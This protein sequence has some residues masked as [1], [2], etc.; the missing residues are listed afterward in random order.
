M[1]SILYADFSCPECYVAANRADILA[2]AG[3]SVDFR[4]VEHQ[5]ELPVPGRRPTA[6]DQDTLRSRFTDLRGLL[7]R[8]EEL[9]WT[10]PP[11]IPKTEAAVSAYA[12]VYG[13]PVDDEV[14]RLLFDLYWREGADIGDPNVLRTPL[15]GAVLRSGSAA[16]PLKQVGYAVSV[17]RSPITTLASRRVRTWRQ[18]WQQ[19]GNPALP[20]L[21]V[22]G[23]TLHGAG[24]VR[25]L[26]KEIIYAGAQVNPDLPDPRRYPHVE[27]RPSL[28]WVSQ[29]G[30]RW[31]NVYRPGSDLGRGRELQG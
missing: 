1:S 24:A 11:L 9:A 6:A 20:V 10:M 19:L 22:D 14:R 31:R 2:A 29:V 3:V 18:E 25:R 30:G 27:V 16:D 12:E 7:L 26:G 4:A 21:L 13:S 23:A 17:N 5:P 15:A 8:G 28:S